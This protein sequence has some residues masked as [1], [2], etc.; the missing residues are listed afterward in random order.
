MWRSP[1][2]NTV[3]SNFWNI[4]TKTLETSE[5][6]TTSYLWEGNNWSDSR[7]LIRN[8]GFRRGTRFFQVLKKKELSTQNS[9]PNEN[10]LQEW[11]E[12]QDILG[13]RKLKRTCHPQISS[14]RIAKESLPHRDNLWKNI[15]YQ[16]GRKNN[17]RK[18]I[19]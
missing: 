11:R 7:F 8:H 14:K 3:Y 10:I 16:K 17:K 5:R 19:K 13:W 18:M 4:K 12:H 6:E 9:R 2:Q 15:E 1:H